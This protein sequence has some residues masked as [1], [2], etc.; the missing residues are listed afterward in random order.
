[1]GET[2]E[3]TVFKPGARRLVH[4]WFLEME[5]VCDMRVC[6]T[7]CV[8]VCVCLSVHLLSVCACVSVSECACVNVS[9]CPCVP[10]Y[11]S[12]HV[13]LSVRVSECV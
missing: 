8:C 12:V 6:L 7:V 1:M 10:V 13:R 2:N 3:Q 4:A 5:F 11:L 9:E